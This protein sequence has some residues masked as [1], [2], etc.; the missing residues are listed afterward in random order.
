[1]YNRPASLSIDE[2]AFNWYPMFQILEGSNI[3]YCSSIFFNNFTWGLG[4]WP[5]NVIISSFL[6][7]KPTSNKFQWMES[8]SSLTWIKFWELPYTA[9]RENNSNRIKDKV[10]ALR[11]GAWCMLNDC[12]IFLY[13]FNINHFSLSQLGVF[14]LMLILFGQK[15]L[16]DDRSCSDPSG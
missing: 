1:M 5:G 10:P 15:S 8:S 4:R 12:T 16:T 9:K 3:K 11:R 6:A 13:R 14:D 2:K 7:W